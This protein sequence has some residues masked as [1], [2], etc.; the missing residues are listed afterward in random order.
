[1]KKFFLILFRF[2]FGQSSQQF[3]PHTTEASSKTSDHK[4]AIQKISFFIVAHPDDIELFMGREAR[5]QILNED[6]ERK[7]FIVLSAGDANRKN[8]KKPLRR[9]SW[10]QAREKAHTTA[11]S[12]WNAH[13]NE[14]SE[15][16]TLINDRY[17][18]EINIGSHIALYNFRLPDADKT[19]SLHQL[20]A[21]EKETIT[22][23]VHQQSY[24]LEDIQNSLIEI[25]ESESQYAEEASFYIMDCDH[26]RNPEDHRDHQATSHIVL[27]V[28]PKLSI[29]NKSLSGYLTYFI[30]TKPINL[31]GEDKLKSFETWALM[32]DVLDCCGYKK[33][34]DEHHMQWVGK[35]Y[36]S[37]TIHPDHDQ[38]EIKNLNKLRDL[39]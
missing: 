30:K 6:I 16:Q 33:N 38:N 7:V 36:K 35:E 15:Q 21:F 26:E 27:D 17:I 14:V 23:L 24:T 9:V 12:F 8:R 10:W 25:I 13:K 29:K 32:G 2:F 11:I 18:T 4:K 22:D 3:F 37:F 39:K 5:H 28:L 20:V 31:E 19:T 1:M 34:D